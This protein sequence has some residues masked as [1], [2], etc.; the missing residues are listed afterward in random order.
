MDD[1]LEWKEERN[2]L[3]HALMKQPLTTDEL[4]ETALKGRA[5]ARKMANKATTYDRPDSDCNFCEVLQ[6]RTQNQSKNN[7]Y[8]GAA[9]CYYFNVS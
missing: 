7:L 3:I 8:L 9:V 1:I 2:R 4:Q 5:L 6:L